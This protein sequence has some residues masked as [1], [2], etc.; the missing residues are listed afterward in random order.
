MNPGLESLKMWLE[1]A[2]AKIREVREGKKSEI[3]ESPASW[4]SKV[5]E[6]WRGQGEGEG[7]YFWIK[8][9][10]WTLFRKYGLVTPFRN[11]YISPRILSLLREM[12]ITFGIDL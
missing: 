1:W 11:L 10:E 7:P 9:L 5:S 6:R 4:T 8:I 2:T 3:N 12:H